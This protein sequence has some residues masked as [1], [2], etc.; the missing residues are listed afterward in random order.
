MACDR[1]ATGCVCRECA[2]RSEWEAAQRAQCPSCRGD[3]ALCLGDDVRPL[4][5][6]VFTPDG[7]LRP[8]VPTIVRQPW[9]TRRAA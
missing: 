5:C 1:Y 4:R 8:E 2:R 6:A 9:E 3:M 7:E